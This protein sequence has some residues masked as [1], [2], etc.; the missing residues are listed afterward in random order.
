M[1]VKDVATEDMF[2]ILADGKNSV[3]EKAWLK[4]FE[5]A[6][7]EIKP[8]KVEQEK[9]EEAEKKEAEPEAEKEKA[10]EEKEK[11]E[12]ETQ[13]EPK[14]SEDVP[15]EKIELSE[16]ELKRVFEFIDEDG[17]GT[18]S[19]EAFN[20]MSTHYMKVIKDTAMTSTM[21]IA[22]GKALRKLAPKEIV[23]V[24]K[25]PMKDEGTKVS[26][27]FC[28]AL[29]DNLEGWVS[30]AGNQ[31]T[32]FLADSTACYK[33]IKKCSMTDS[34]EK[35]EDGSVLSPGLI[36]EVREPPRKDEESGL[37]RMKGRVKGQPAKSGTGYVTIS[38][39]KGKVFL[40]EY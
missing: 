18:L 31:G 1:S 3:N 37:M 23:H 6:D 34:F 13:E 33:V 36:L 16:D 40:R 12:E 2:G 4:F 9:K 30:V 29:K 26:R 21:G 28:K 25:G 11:K 27:I 19:R 38:D 35:T 22:G 5:T 10:D 32:A 24:L 20:E 15:G 17:S 8:L 7:M 39:K 14:K